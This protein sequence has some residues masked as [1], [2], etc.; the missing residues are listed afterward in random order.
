[1]VVHGAAH[2]AGDAPA[3]RDI[4]PDANGIVV[5]IEAIGYCI[6]KDFG[7]FS[8][9]PIQLLQAPVEH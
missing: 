6:Q 9:D 2:L 1:L 3:V 7:L 8:S 4:I 5:V